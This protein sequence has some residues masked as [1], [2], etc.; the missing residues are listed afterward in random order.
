MVPAIVLI[1]IAALFLAMAVVFI[2]IGEVL[3]AIALVLASTFTMR[4]ALKGDDL[5][6]D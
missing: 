3:I 5:D 2:V 1:V 6:G 4:T